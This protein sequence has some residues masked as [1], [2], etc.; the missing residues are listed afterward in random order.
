MVVTQIYLEFS[1]WQMMK[2][3]CLVPEW[4]QGLKLVISEARLVSARDT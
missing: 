4:D 1:L 3:A 2:K